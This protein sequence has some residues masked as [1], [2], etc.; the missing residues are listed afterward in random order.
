MDKIKE[1]AN[2]VGQLVFASDTGELYKKTFIRTWEILKETGILVWLVICLTFVGAEW[3]YRTSVGL[4][5][6]ARIWYNGLGE[7]AEKSEAQSAA[8]TGQAVLDTVQSGATYLLSQARKQLGL[9][10]PEPLPTAA[11][12]SQPTVD[13]APPEPAPAAV[14]VE[15]AAVAEPEVE[16]APP[17]LDQ[18]DEDDADA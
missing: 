10:D 12:P 8:S 11:A 14:K 7:K 18:S 2:Q 9:K 3:F 17:D 15:P 13:S 1:Q 16:S 4:G 5:R 6:N